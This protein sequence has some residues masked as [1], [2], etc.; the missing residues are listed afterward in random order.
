M[1]G[2]QTL[3]L[4]I[5]VQ[6]LVPE[7]NF[8]QGPLTHSEEY[9]PFKFGARGSKPRRPT[10][11]GRSMPQKRS[12]VWAI[13]PD[14]FM[15]LVKNSGSYS[16]VLRRLGL[17]PIG[18]NHKT[19]K[20]RIQ[21]ES[22][23]VKHFYKK[24][25]R[26]YKRI[27]LEEILKKGITYNTCCL[28]NRLVETGLLQNFCARCKRPPEWEG[29]KLS[30][31]LDHVDGDRTNNEIG[32]LRLLCP[33]CHSLTP[34]YTGKKR[35]G[36]S[37]IDLGVSILRKINACACGKTIGPTSKCC[38]KCAT[39]SRQKLTRVRE[40]LLPSK[41]VLLEMIR[42]KSFVTIGKHFGVSDNA[43]RKWFR[44]YGL[45]PKKYSFH[46]KNS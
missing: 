8:S 4:S 45:D 13:S 25:A 36:R 46:R 12:V 33:N 29:E 6:P 7:P 38:R 40:V 10:N 22:L 43:V 32:N 21:E 37:Y 11:I 41:E 34:N 19:V 5:Q 23:D 15:T 9:E 28:K 42:E 26:F 18:A 24:P 16:D 20:R 31:H 35:K 39:N 3:T 1:A 2:R 27:P 30:L 17:N 44:K 14:E